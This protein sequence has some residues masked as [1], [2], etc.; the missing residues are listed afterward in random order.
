MKKSK[1]SVMTG[2]FRSLR[3]VKTSVGSSYYPKILGTYE[4]ELHDLI[5]ALCKERFERIVNVGAAEGYYAVGMAVRCPHSQVVAA[6][7]EAEGRQ[8][9]AEMVQ[10]NNVSQRVT[11][12]GACN[13][14]NLPALLTGSSQV[15]SLVIMDIEGAEAELLDPEKVADLKHCT[16]LVEVHDGANTGP[17]GDQLI[18]RFQQ[19]HKITRMWSRKR[20]ISDLP[21]QVPFVTRHL[22]ELMNEGRKVGLC[23]MI[24]RPISQLG[25]S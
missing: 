9:L 25:G 5:E 10:M 2:P 3:Y 12:F 8:L 17:I 4:L 19:T 16:I 13:V 24:M 20:H 1:G 11:I 21:L 6:E 22:A 15:K 23:W 7:M 14:T 18:E